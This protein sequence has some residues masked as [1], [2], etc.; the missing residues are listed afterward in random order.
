[1]DII[2]CRSDDAAAEAAFRLLYQVYGAEIGVAD[3]AIDHDKQI[4]IDEFDSAA[5]IYVA[6]KDGAAVAT[7]RSVYDRDFDFR[8]DLPNSIFDMLGLDNFLHDYS[9]A[10]AIST[11][12]AISPS[13][14]G[15]LAAHLVTA[16][17]FDDIINNAVG[18]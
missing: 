14:R 12:F 18:K 10:L 11:K 8:R 9:G 1:M 6:M 4:Y 5:R 3:A 16:K 7:C 2:C 17:M 15:S 13:H